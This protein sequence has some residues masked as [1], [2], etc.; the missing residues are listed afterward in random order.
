MLLIMAGAVPCLCQPRFAF[1]IKPLQRHPRKCQHVNE[2]SGRMLLRSTPLDSSP[3]NVPGQSHEEE[4]LRMVR[5]LLRVFV[6]LVVLTL[7][8]SLSPAAAQE[9]T[10]PAEQAAGTPEPATFRVVAAGFIEVLAP[11][12]ANVVLGRISL[13]PGASIP[14]DPTDPSAILVYMATGELTFRVDVPMSVARAAGA[15]TPTPPEAVE[16]DTEFTLGKGDSALFPG[17]MAGE[18]R[19]AG[20]D[21]AAAWVVDIVYLVAADATPTP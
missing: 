11:S 15:G 2:P 14:F 4:K 16:A 20:A 17:T 5:P 19:N 12:T 8:G 7:L 21:P 18:V 3:P 9:A 1:R 13:P 6:L 10:P